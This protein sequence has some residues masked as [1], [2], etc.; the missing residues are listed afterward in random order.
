[1]KMTQEQYEQFIADCLD[2]RE[3]RLHR[4]CSPER[5]LLELSGE[6]GELIN[7]FKHER[8]WPFEQ[9]PSAVYVNYNIDKTLDEAG[10][11]L[12]YLTA[13][14]YQLG[15]SLEEV[16]SLNA[17]KIKERYGNK[18]ENGSSGE[19]RTRFDDRT[20]IGG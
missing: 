4:K 13:I 6:V 8:L 18:D 11:V 2:D 14:L 19:R 17:T 1:M 7:A 9:Q 10:D 20:G 5:L 12:W 16:M 3:N 15:S